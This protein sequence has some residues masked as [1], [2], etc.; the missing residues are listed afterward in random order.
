MPVLTIPQLEIARHDYNY[1]AYHKKNDRPAFSN[2]KQEFQDALGD[3]DVALQGR[4]VTWQIAASNRG[5]T[6]TE[7][8]VLLM[9]RTLINRRLAN[10]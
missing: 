5:I 8:E 6:L 1:D 9:I 2:T 4:V 7:S 10:V 3:L